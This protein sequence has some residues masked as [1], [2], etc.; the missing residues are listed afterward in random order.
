MQPWNWPPRN[1][2]VQEGSHTRLLLKRIF[3][4]PRHDPQSRSKGQEFLPKESLP[5]LS[6][7][8]S[9]PPPHGCIP[10]PP[11]F[12]GQWQGRLRPHAS[13]WPLCTVWCDNLMPLFILLLPEPWPGGLFCFPQGSGSSRGGGSWLNPAGFGLVNHPQTEGAKCLRVSILLSSV[14]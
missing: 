2:V 5:Q 9:Q 7:E 4:Q 6:V 10:T 11:Q 1:S 14:C 3:P 13:H 8:F 12:F